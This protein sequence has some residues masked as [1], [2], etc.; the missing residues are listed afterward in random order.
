VQ[1]SFGLTYV[2]I[3]HDLSVVEHL[4]D[5]VAVMYLGRI[6]EM[7]GVAELYRRPLHPYTEALLSAIPSPDPDVKRQR[8]VLQGTPPSPLNPP[9][10]CLFNTRC[11][12]AQARCGT[13]TPALVE[14]RP[15]H[16]VACHFAEALELQG[17]TAPA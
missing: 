16:Q 2:F 15:G 17:I 6:V 10:G 5:R 11:R 3:S 4:A 7:A 12:Y 1:E 13:E 14:L 9:V 8:I